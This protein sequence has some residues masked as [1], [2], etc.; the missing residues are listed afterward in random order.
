M[1][2]LKEHFSKR[3]FDYLSIIIIVASVTLLLSLTYRWDRI[4]F[5]V[6]IAYNGG[7]AITNLVNAKLMEEQAWSIDRPRLAAPYT[8]NAFDFSTCVLHNFDL[9]T[10]K[11]CVKATDAVHGSNLNLYLLYYLAA[12]IAYFVF[13]ELGIKRWISVL[14]SLAFA[15]TPYITAR[16][17]P[18]GHYQ[19]AEAYFVP[20]SIL[21]CIWLYEREDVLK[22]GK[23]ALKN[24][25]NWLALLFIILISNNGIIYYPFFTCYLLIIVAIIKLLQTKKVKAML[26]SFTAIAGIGLFI[27][28]NMLPKVIYN[29][30]NGSNAGAVVRSGFTGPEYYGLKIIQLFMPYNSKLGIV[31]N[32]A[33]ENY[34]ATAPFVT[35]NATAY[36]GIPAILGLLILFVF[37]FKKNQNEM[38][39]RMRFY[40]QLNIFMVLLAAGNGIGT[41]FAAFVSDGIRGYCRI[42]VF[43]VF[44]SLIGLATAIQELTKRFNIKAVAVVS[45]LLCCM[46]IWEQ[47]PVFK[48][49]MLTNERDYYSDKAFVER[50]EALEEPGS[51]IYQLPYHIYPEG[52]PQNEMEDYNHFLGMLH[53]DSLRWSYGAMKGRPENDY[54]KEIAELPFDERVAKLKETGFA[55]IYVDRRAYESDELAELESS[56]EELTGSTAFISENGN[57]SYFHFN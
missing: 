56:L 15:F 1:V 26:P 51:M 33:I 43:I 41:I 40:A 7:D 42:V 38:T 36:M 9:L 24:K 18:F 44:V 25:S 3:K 35:E 29:M 34:S 49:D 20:L 11:L 22:F 54:Q 23:G 8:T 14:M 37:F 52:G 53:S 50:I 57:L 4:N 32:D 31:F 39:R 10:L 5:D 46:G 13:R 48:D 30:Q 16:I 55:G 28:L 2:K 27:I 17:V 6:P 19:L 47:I 12:L 21:L 45:V